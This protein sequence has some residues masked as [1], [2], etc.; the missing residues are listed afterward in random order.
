[1]SEKM[2]VTGLQ[3]L[4]NKGALDGCF[5]W[6]LLR[7]TSLP[8]TSVRWQCSVSKTRYRLS[9]LD[10]VSLLSVLMV[11]F[12]CQRR[13]TTSITA[14]RTPGLATG[15]GLRAPETRR[16]AA[17]IFTSLRAFRLG[18][19]SWIPPIV[20]QRESPPGFVLRVRESKNKYKSISI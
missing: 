8:A 10:S 20:C 18:A 2:V 4:F 19:I 3:G 15:A 6:L 16:S 13:E 9:R 7:C 11:Q 17:P 1:M 14:R 5:Q 12:T